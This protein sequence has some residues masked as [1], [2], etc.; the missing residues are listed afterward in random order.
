MSATVFT[1][2]PALRIIFSSGERRGLDSNDT[3]PAPPRRTNARGD[4]I[5]PHG[6]H[7][8]GYA[9]P[10]PGDWKDR[11][12]SQ[13]HFAGLMQSH[14]RKTR[15]KLLRSAFCLPGFDQHQ[16]EWKPYIRPGHLWH[17]RERPG[18]SPSTCTPFSFSA[19]QSFLPRAEHGDGY[20]CFCKPGCK[21][22]CKAPVPRMRYQII[23]SS[24][25]PPL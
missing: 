20:A 13:I 24:D 5:C 3:G 23:Y 25:T 12:V 21:K 16:S 11:I 2:K 18:L 17:E 6:S 4:Q 15:R 22:C 1:S 19:C 7:T 10:V 9:T 14:F 8:Q